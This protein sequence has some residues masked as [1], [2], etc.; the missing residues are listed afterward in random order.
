VFYDSG[1]SGK[2]SCKTLVILALVTF[3]W[4]TITPY[5]FGKN[6]YVQGVVWGVW[7]TSPYYVIGDIEVPETRELYIMPGVEVFF[8]G[9][10]TFEVRGLLSAEGGDFDGGRILMTTELSIPWWGITFIECNALSSIINCNIVNAWTGLDC[11]NSFVFVQGDTIDARNVGIN[12][13]NS[14]PEIVNNPLIIVR[15]NYN[16]RASL[17]AISLHDESSPNIIDNDRIQCVANNNSEAYGIYIR[18]GSS[19]TISGNWIEVSSNYRAIGIYATELNSLSITRNIIRTKS[20]RVMRGMEISDATGIDLTNNNVILI[21][22]SIYTPIG[23]LIDLGSRVT[24]TNNIILGN[25]NSIGLTAPSGHIN[26]G[27]GFN[28]FFRHHENY[29]GGWE[30]YTDIHNDPLFESEDDNPEFADYQLTWVNYPIEDHTKS[31][32][33]DTG[34][35]GSPRDPDHTICD[36]GRYWFEQDTIANSAADIP[37]AAEYQLLAAYPNPFNQTATLTFSPPLPGMGKLVLFDLHGRKLQTLWSG[38]MTA[39]PYHILWQAS[40]HPAGEYIIQL[41]TTHGIESTR[42]ILLP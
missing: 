14:S 34:D 18:E 9:N 13:V 32:C 22:P 6:S 30:G 19:P 31:P 7:D 1:F 40:G 16:P 26:S 15:E 39:D 11:I 2:S 37:P 21:G 3:G 42:L 29:Q 17:K 33:I 28:N 4:V 27:S 38:M 20:N 35:P 25:F 24:L 8:L 41:E 12:C 10:Y 23:L 5:A 36:I